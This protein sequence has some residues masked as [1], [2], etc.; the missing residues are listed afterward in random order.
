MV[1]RISKFIENQ[2][3]S[4][5]SFEQKISA[6]NGLIR[7]AIA[8]HTDIQSKWATAIVVNFPQINPE[9]L[10]T[11]NGKMLLEKEYAADGKSN[12]AVKPQAADH[13]KKGEGYHDKYMTELENLKEVTELLKENRLLRIEVDRLRGTGFTHRTVAVGV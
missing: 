3:I 4:I 9:W 10:L 5:R 8:N 12:P 2:G 1:E 7:K 6:S 11:G 13:K